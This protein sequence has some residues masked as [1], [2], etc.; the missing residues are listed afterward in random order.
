VAIRLEADGLQTTAVPERRLGRFVIPLIALLIGLGL[1][2]VLA[3]KGPDTTQ[4]ESVGPTRVENEVPLGY[5]RS[6]KGAVSAAG[7]FSKVLLGPLLAKPDAY[8]KANEIMASPSRR[9]EAAENAQ[10][11]ID[12]FEKEYGLTS[13]AAQGVRVGVNASPMRYKVER[14]TQQKA[15][16]LLWIVVVVDPGPDQSLEEIWTAGRYELEWMNGDWRLSDAE[17]IEA[18][19]PGQPSGEISDWNVYENAP[20]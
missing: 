20:S 7:N 6:E 14:F 1:G 11:D 4:P 18:P 17:A 13:K 16:I 2:Y 12:T 5:A 9:A 3:P 19:E 8:K 10:R 15:T